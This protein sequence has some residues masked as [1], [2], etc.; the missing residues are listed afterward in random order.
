MILKFPDDIYNVTL[1]LYIWDKDKFE[2]YAWE[3]DWDSL[4]MFYADGKKCHIYLR[5][6]NHQTLVH[7]L[8]HFVMYVFDYCWVNISYKNDEVFAYYM[9]YYYGMII[10]KL[11]KKVK[12]KNHHTR[13]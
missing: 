11:K 10:E 6:I 7:E 5:E 13:Q 12:P 1:T 8:I 9:D 2:K 3:Q 4:G